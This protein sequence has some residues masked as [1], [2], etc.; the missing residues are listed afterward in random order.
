LLSGGRLFLIR[1]E[2]R[3]DISGLFNFIKDRNIEVVFFP[4]PLLK[5]VFSQDEFAVMIPS[6][7]KHIITAGEQ[8][9]VT[10]RMK[11][12]LKQKKIHLHN[13]Y[14]PSETHVVTTFVISPDSDTDEL[15]PIGRPISNTSIFILDKNKNIQPVGVMGELCISG[16]CLGNGYINNPEMTKLKFVPN[17]YIEGEFMYLTG[18]IA[19]WLPDGNIQ[20]LGRSDHQVK[21]RGYRIEPGEIEAKLLSHTMVKEAAVIAKEDKDKNKY[22]CAYVVTEGKVAPAELREHLLKELP[23]Y[24]IPSYFVQ[25]DTMP[26]TSTGK[27]NRKLLP[28]PDKTVDAGALYAAPRNEEE[29]KLADIWAKVLGLEKVGIDDEFF[30]IG[31]DSIKALRIAG[32]AA[33]ENIQISV[34]NIFKY[35]TISK[36]LENSAVETNKAKTAGNDTKNDASDALDIIEIKD[37]WPIAKNFRIYEK[38]VKELKIQLQRDITV[39]MH[40]SLSLCVIMADENLHPWF[41]ERFINIFSMVNQEGYLTLDYLEVWAP[42]REIINEI[43]LGTEL[44]EKEMDIIRFIN[45]KIDM[46]YY[47]NIAVDEF[48]LRGKEKYQKTHFIHHALVYGY[49]NINRKVKV[50]GFGAGNVLDRISFDYDNFVEAYEKGKEYYKKSAPWTS[51]TAVQMFFSNGFDKP[52]PFNP[53]KVVRQLHDYL[54]SKGDDAIIYYWALKQ[55]QITYGF[56]AY[57]VIINHLEAF[58]EGKFSTDYRAIHL[59]AEHKKVI[60]QRLQY[61]IDSYRIDGRLFE[62]C[63]EYMKVVEAFNEL[64]IKYFDLEYSFSAQALENSAKELGMSLRQVIDMIKSA[65]DKERTLLLEIYELLKDMFGEA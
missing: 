46:G 19:R 20:F 8:L 6:S 15:P 28:E 4:V 9:V 18:D 17:P 45:E 21:I 56:G 27:V 55:E 58:F 63:S 64:R 24:M 1:K 10:E 3:D 11:E 38:D 47:L 34:K 62:L 41:Y 13:H 33:R 35:K 23:D 22:L 5:L 44:L 43:S 57:D 12:Y 26:L 14:G 29:R 48:Y 30:M 54:F 52:Y 61:I 50:I 51:R 53:A 39:Y 59:L 42:Y 16:E 49:D 60:G 37:R 36:I 2:V 40:R 32:E 31:G 7:V 25:M 65:R